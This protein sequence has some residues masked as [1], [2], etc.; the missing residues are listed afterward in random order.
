VESKEEISYIDYINKKN[1]I[2]K[3][4][5]NNYNDCKVAILKSYTID[6]IKP[7]LEVEAYEKQLQ[8]NVYIGDYNNYMS[9]ILEV[10][11]EYNVF[12]PDVTILALRLE[13]LYPQIFKSFEQIEG[14]L[15]GV[16]EYILNYY[17]SLILNIKERNNGVVFVNNFIVPHSNYGA[18]ITSSVNSQKNFIRGI[19]IAFDELAKEFSD[20]YI[21]DNENVASEVG[22]SNIYDEKMWY[23]SKNPYKMR[24]YINLSKEYAK[25]VKAIRGK[26]KKCIVL[27]LDNTIWGGV[28]GEEGINNIKLSETYPGKCYKDFQIE[29]KRLKKQGILLCICS[30]NN[31]KDTE[32]IFLKHPDMEL[33]FDDFILK[34]INWNEKSE[35]IIEIAKELNI[36]LDSM[37]FIDDSPF[38]CSMV[39]ESLPDVA[40]IQVPNTPYEIPNL[41]NKYNYFD[42][43]NI[44]EEDKVKSEQYIGKIKADEF[45]ST[46]KNIEEF[47]ESLQMKIE[48]QELNEMYISRVS[49]LTQKTNQFNLTTKRLT[50][51]EIA[52]MCK[53][54][55]NKVLYISVEDKFVNHGVVGCAFLNITQDSLEIENL[56]I[57][58]RVIGRNIETAFMSY[59]Y[60]L[61]RKLNVNEIIGK[62]IS[63]TKNIIAKDFYI[64][65]GFLCVGDGRFKLNINKKRIL[66][67]EYINMV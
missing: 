41:L 2:K 9:E 56:M 14:D 5:G 58:C 67:P 44:T 37:V 35:N 53:K 36:G 12:A 23:V 18:L 39:A 6:I 32:E 50:E 4:D 52:D 63:T 66:K 31:L 38:E 25:Y 47:Y 16:Q 21:I 64:K 26:R 51:N 11:S 19:N 15:N 30:K 13:E 46:L 17:K 40:V 22:K 60:D 57:S 20:V 8:L 28:I 33:A 27:D 45:R 48:I 34:K 61:A 59:I 42:T 7:I 65:L 55:G 54:E 43:L 1:K 10:E 62:Y 49:Q 29:I 24:Y 3:F